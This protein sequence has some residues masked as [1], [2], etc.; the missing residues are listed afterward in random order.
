MFLF[1]ALKV[2]DFFFFFTANTRRVCEEGGATGRTRGLWG[3]GVGCAF[4][5]GQKSARKIKK[6]GYFRR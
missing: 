1:F 2:T 4:V 6:G 3:K 5:G